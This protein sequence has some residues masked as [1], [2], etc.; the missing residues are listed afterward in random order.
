MKKKKN[1]NNNN[2][3]SPFSFIIVSII[4]AIIIRKI[5]REMQRERVG[6]VVDVWQQI[7]QRRAHCL[8]GQKLRHGTS[9]MDALKQK[10]IFM[11]ILR[12]F[13]YVLCIDYKQQIKPIVCCHM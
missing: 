1:N 7:G 6:G 2:N 5:W 11:Y 4:I 9:I 10:K 12:V 13:A 8:Y 3:N